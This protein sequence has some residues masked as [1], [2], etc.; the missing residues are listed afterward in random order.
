MRSVSESSSAIWDCHN[1]AGEEQSQLDRVDLQEEKTCEI[2]ACL[3]RERT[4]DL[5]GWSGW[6][7]NKLFGIT[8][9]IEE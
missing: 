5:Q 6:I 8:L 1:S 4:N 7:E 2:P 3:E 9:H